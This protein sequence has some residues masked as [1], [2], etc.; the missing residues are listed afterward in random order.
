MYQREFAYCEQNYRS[1]Q[2]KTNAGKMH[3][4]NKDLIIVVEKT[5]IWNTDK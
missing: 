4:K 3:V 5:M 2:Q 1:S